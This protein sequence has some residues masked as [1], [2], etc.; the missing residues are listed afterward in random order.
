MQDK[1]TAKKTRANG[2]FKRKLEKMKNETL[3]N[4]YMGRKIRLH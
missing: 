1:K 4:I 3:N 2:N